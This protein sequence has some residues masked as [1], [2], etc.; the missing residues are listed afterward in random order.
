MFCRWSS[1][2]DE[3]AINNTK[4][5]LN[6]WLRNENHTLFL[7]SAKAIGCT[8][9]N[10]GT[11]DLVEARDVEELKRLPPEKVLLKWMNFHA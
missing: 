3:R 2:V 8:V 9:V 6:Q 7:N 10:I 4:G 5:F 1:V 11:Q